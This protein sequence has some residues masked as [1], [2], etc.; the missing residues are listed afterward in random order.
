MWGYHG[1]RLRI[2]SS[3]YFG[4]NSK[5]EGEYKMFRGKNQINT[6]NVMAEE[7]Y[8]KEVKES[9]LKPTHHLIGRGV[10][11]YLKKDL[12]K[13]SKETRLKLYLSCSYQG[14]PIY[15]RLLLPP[16]IA[17]LSER[18]MGSMKDVFKLLR[19]VDRF[20]RNLKTILEP[21]SFDGIK[22]KLNC[23]QILALNSIYNSTGKCLSPSEINSTINSY[24][25]RIT[26]VQDVIESRRK[27]ALTYNDSKNIDSL[28]LNL[29][30]LEKE[31]KIYSTVNEITKGLVKLEKPKE[32]VSEV[33]HSIK[34]R[35]SLKLVS[36]NFGHPHI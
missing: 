3:Y 23:E 2:N 1:G 19:T 33:A 6:Q 14:I 4:W 36:S 11:E 9:G 13:F 32:K 27:V 20:E 15:D 21:G 34:V 35:E 30:R 17:Q 28:V 16:E 18:E 24:N 8:R 26:R 5:I 7:E 31:R 12:P 22:G 29:Q 10:K 25:D